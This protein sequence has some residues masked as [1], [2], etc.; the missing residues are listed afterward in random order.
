MMHGLNRYLR[1]QGV[2]AEQL[3]P[4][5]QGA[6]P[7]NIIDK[8][9]DFIAGAAGIPKRILIG[10]ERGELASTQDEAA[11]SSRI[12][13]RREQH[14]TPNML[15]PTID[16]LMKLG[17]LDRQGYEI[18]CRVRIRSRRSMKTMPRSRISSISRC[19]G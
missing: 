4:G 1:T 19:S 15:A 7:S 14:A 13:E 18:E 9:L 10:S 2:D 8:E 3:A 6:D 12:M 11:W 5:M 16:R 17:C